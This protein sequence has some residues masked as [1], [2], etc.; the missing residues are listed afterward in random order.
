MQS[1]CFHLKDNVKPYIRFGHRVNSFI[2]CL[3]STAA[4][5]ESIDFRQEKLA[6]VIRH[7]LQPKRQR[8]Q[9]LIEQQ[10]VKQSPGAIVNSGAQ[11]RWPE[12]GILQD[13]KM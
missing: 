1:G 7:N 4:E 12:T 11:R 9:K 6:A 3:K 13:S 8:C 2:S 5:T 10:H